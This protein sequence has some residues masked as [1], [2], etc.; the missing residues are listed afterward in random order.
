MD[1]FFASIGHNLSRIVDPSGRESNILFWPYAI[2]IAALN[3]IGGSLIAAPMMTEMFQRIM[4]M[5]AE[6]GT[7]PPPTNP[8]EIM[9]DMT[10]LVVP[11]AAILAATIVLLFSAV[12][13]RL[14]D[15][16]R[17]G[18]WGLMPVPFAAAAL[19]F[20]PMMF[21]RMAEGGAP[22]PALFGALMLNNFAYLGSLIA[23]IVLLVGKGTPGPNRFGPAPQ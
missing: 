19:A 17:T 14:H 11:Q 7:R 18:L 4:V 9:P 15:R 23:L 10:E 3:Y 12:A 1:K 20:A 2:L 6:A 5:V 21:D 16:D 8:F 13:R 22:D